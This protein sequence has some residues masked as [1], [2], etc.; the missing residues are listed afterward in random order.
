LYIDFES[1][2][3]KVSERVMA[4][5]R[6]FGLVESAVLAAGARFRYLR[7]QGNPLGTSE[8]ARGL[9]AQLV[10]T[11]EAIPRGRLG[12]CVV[13]GVTRAFSLMGNVSTNDAD[14]VSRW[15]ERFPASVA[16]VCGKSVSVVMIDHVV[17][18]AESRGRYAVGSQAKITTLD[19]ASY[20][21]KMLDRFTKTTSGKIVTYL[22]KDRDGD[23]PH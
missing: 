19:G 1:N 8:V 18:S 16:R 5:L 22:A 3:A 15:F 10:A 17:K 2:R 6:G 11:V 12:L 4:F 13:D 9:Q 20:V 14:E 7:P 21:V 23:I